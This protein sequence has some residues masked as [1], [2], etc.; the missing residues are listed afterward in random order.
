M[1]FARFGIIRDFKTR[2]KR[3]A[4]SFKVV[5]EFEL[6]RFFKRLGLLF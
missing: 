4:S 5:E 6:R 2:P 3:K 1:A